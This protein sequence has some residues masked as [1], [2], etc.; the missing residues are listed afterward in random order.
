MDSTKFQLFAEILYPAYQVPSRKYLS[1]VLLNKKYLAVKN[2]ILQR[3]A[4]VKTIHLT[5]DL[6]SNRQMKSCLGITGHYISEDWV[7]QSF[8][9]GCNR[10]F[11]RHTSDNI[12][13]WYDDIVTD[14]D[15]GSKV[16]H[17]VTDSGANIKKAFRSLTLPGYDHNQEVLSESEDEYEVADEDDSSLSCPSLQSTLLPVVMIEHHACFAHTLQLVVKDGLTK[18]GQAGIVIIKCSNLVSF[19]RR[20]TVAADVLQHDKRLQACNSTRWNSQLKMIR[21]VLSVP[22]SKLAE[23][24]EAPKL[25]SHERNILK[26]ICEI[27][28]PFEEATDF[29]QTSCVP[30]AG[31]VLPCIRGLN[32]HMQAISSK[33]HS[34]FVLALKES[35]R[36]RLSYFEEKEVYITAAILDPRFKLHG[37]WR[38]L[39]KRSPQRSF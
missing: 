6:W 36:K 20:S 21:S 8:M 9:L 16:K 1:T 28:T 4:E 29:V 18:V 37:V 7:L 26:D 3:L 12:V 10:V 2:K 27:L 38:K 14:F 19:V 11:G 30:S 25:T 23:L 31:Y 33:Y 5:I 35:L 13:S 32:H 15:V 34:T 22:E 17:I 39:R 24:V